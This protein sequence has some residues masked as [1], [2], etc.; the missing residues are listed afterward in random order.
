[1]KISRILIEMSSTLIRAISP[2]SIPVGLPYVEEAFIA[3]TYQFDGTLTSRRSDQALITDP[4][5]AT[6]Q[7]LDLVLKGKVQALNGSEVKIHADTLCVHGDNPNA[8]VLLAR[9]RNK[10]GKRASKFCHWT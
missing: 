1:M 5:R 10:G 9:V 3:R 8:V 4:E 7:A 6:Q 2:I